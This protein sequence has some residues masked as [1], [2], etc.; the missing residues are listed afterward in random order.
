VTLDL[1]VQYLAGGGA[2]LLPVRLRS[3][4]RPKSIPPIEGFD[5]FV[6]GN[7]PVK[8]G[9]IRRGE[10]LEVEEEEEGGGERASAAI[11]PKEVKLP[12]IDVALDRFGST[13]TT[14]SPLPKV[15]IPKELLTE[16]E[17]MDP[18]GEIQTV[19]SKIPLWHSRYLIGIKPDSWALSKEAFKFHV[20]VLDLSNKPVPNAPVNIDLFERKTY[21]H[22]KRLVDSMPTSIRWRRRELQ[23]SVKGRLIPTAF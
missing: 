13:R 21:T 10:P 1:G 11:E 23:P 16:M 19:S 2:G 8:E 5:Q 14:I 7:G 6:F 20:A 12:V 9:L 18:N 4:V 17:F 15:E 3:E 22:R